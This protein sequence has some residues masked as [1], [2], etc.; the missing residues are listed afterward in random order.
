M[1]LGV[2]IM[3]RNLRKIQRG[4]PTG[5][6]DPLRSTAGGSPPA[7]GGYA[8]PAVIQSNSAYNGG[9][10]TLASNSTTGN[11]LVVFISGNATI[12]ATLGTGTTNGGGV[13]TWT[14]GTVQ[15]ST[16]VTYG[17]FYYGVVT[18]GSAVSI[19]MEDDPADPGW[20]I[21]EISNVAT[22]TPFDDESG[23]GGTNFFD[24]AWTSG[25]ATASIEKAAA[26]GAWA[27]ENGLPETMAW[28]SGWGNTTLQNTHWHG[29]AFRAITVAGDY[30]ASGTNTGGAV[31]GIAMILILK[32]KAL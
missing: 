4:N 20:S 9:P 24:G 10:I 23:A 25:V 22:T 15:A 32:A 28:D 7:A 30:Q 11:T 27:S 21:Y 29:T 14:P 8:T 6:G 17:R 2:W 31:D 1:I 12:A 13:S 3:S 19:T 26:I 5:S 18:T 16:T